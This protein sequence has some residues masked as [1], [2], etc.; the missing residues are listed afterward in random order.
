MAKARSC[1]GA[2]RTGGEGAHLFAQR[3]GAEPLLARVGRQ[4]LYCYRFSLR[5]FVSTPTRAAVE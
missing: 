1:G 5:R 2:C 4:R 3:S